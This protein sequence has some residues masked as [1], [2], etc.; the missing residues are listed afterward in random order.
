MSTWIVVTSRL[1][2]VD[3]LDVRRR[4]PRPCICP[5][6]LLLFTFIIDLLVT[7]LRSNRTM[8]FIALAAVANVVAATIDRPLGGR[9]P[10]GR[11]R[12]PD[13]PVRGGVPLPVR[14]AGSPRR[15]RD[16]RP[17]PFRGPRRCVH[18]VPAGAHGRLPRRARRD[19]RRARCRSATLDTLRSYHGAARAR[20]APS[21]RACTS[22]CTA[23]RPPTGRSP[24]DSTATT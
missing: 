3:D 8:Q 10:P 22:R 18:P 11:P 14:R 24:I 12:P 20:S 13:R 19:G 1:I 15:S 21:S 4:S 2:F 17:R 6:R 9:S 5:W 7:G 16:G 23:T